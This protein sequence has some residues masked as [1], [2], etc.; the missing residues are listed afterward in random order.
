MAKGENLQSA[1]VEGSIV[2]A[3]IK[4]PPTMVVESQVARSHQLIWLTL[5]CIA[6]SHLNYF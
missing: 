6:N 5:I 2:D 3:I 1:K 4:P